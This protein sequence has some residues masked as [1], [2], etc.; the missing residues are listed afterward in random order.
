MTREL[1]LNLDMTCQLR[2]PLKIYFD[3][4]GLFLNVRSLFVLNS[5]HFT[6]NTFK[7]QNEAEELQ[8]FDDP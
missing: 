6:S 2:F 5:S 4:R 8:D 7:R 1:Y 3:L